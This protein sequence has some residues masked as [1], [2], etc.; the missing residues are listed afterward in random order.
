M[1]KS[2]AEQELDAL[3][4]AWEHHLSGFVSPI[5]FICRQRPPYYYREYKPELFVAAEVSYPAANS[6]DFECF[7][8]GC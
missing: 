2:F 7:I 3:S 4:G 8:A 1:T 6:K 5:V